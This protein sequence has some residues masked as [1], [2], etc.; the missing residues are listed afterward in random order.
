VLGLALG[1][2]FVH[3]ATGSPNYSS[4][5]FVGTS[6]QSTR[7]FNWRRLYVA[8]TANRRPGTANSDAR[9]IAATESSVPS[10]P[11]QALWNRAIK[12]WP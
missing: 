7:D 2:Y 10:L 4:W 9:R 1:E 5:D 12:E 8:N 6:Y 3:R 11:L